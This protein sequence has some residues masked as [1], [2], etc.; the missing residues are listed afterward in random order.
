METKKILTK[1]NIKEFR[2]VWDQKWSPDP[3]IIMGYNKYSMDYNFY[4][5]AFDP[6]T[7]VLSWF[8]DI[9]GYVSYTLEEIQYFRDC[10]DDWERIDYTRWSKLSD[11]WIQV[12]KSWDNTEPEEL[13]C[14]SEP[15]TEARHVFK[16]IASILFKK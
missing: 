12:N 1:E 14:N 3:F 11:L 4:G 5:I 16:D 13:E 15:N 6:K 2:R 9:E 7:N 8:D 10:A